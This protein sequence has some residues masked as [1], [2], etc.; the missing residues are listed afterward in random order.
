MTTTVN[1]TNSSP[2]LRGPQLWVP[3]NAAAALITDTNEAAAATEYPGVDTDP[4]S[5]RTIVDLRAFNYAKLSVYIGSVAPD[6]DFY[7]GVQYSVDAGSTWAFLNGLTLLNAAPAIGSQL[8]ADAGTALTV[9]TPVSSSW[10]ALTST[11]KSENAW[12][13]LLGT[14]GDGVID[15]VFGNIGVQFSA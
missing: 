8:A 1:H 6:E 3:F 13:R 11:A 5:W 7:L 9:S 4:L 2:N 10:A 14:R 15:P 12:L